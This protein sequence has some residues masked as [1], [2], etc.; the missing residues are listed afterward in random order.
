[1]RRS[2]ILLALLVGCT[3][4]P[5][6][7][8]EIPVPTPVKCVDPSAIPAEPPRV[9]ERFNGNARHDLEVLAPNAVALREW[10]RELLALLEQCVGKAPES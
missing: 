5:A 1:M 7:I 9:S 6:E 2:L 8:R 10:G 3:H 4:K